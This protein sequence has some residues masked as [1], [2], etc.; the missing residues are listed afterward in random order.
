MNTRS[1]DWISVNM[2]RRDIL[3]NKFGVISS[4][5]GEKTFKNS[6]LLTPNEIGRR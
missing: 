1:M 3:F 2:G 6:E 4:Q 5:F